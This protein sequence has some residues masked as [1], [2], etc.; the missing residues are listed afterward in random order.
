MSIVNKQTRTTDK[1]WS[2][3][4][5]VGYEANNPH[6]KRYARYETFQ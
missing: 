6:S 1:G 2:S 4:L 3:S 5:D